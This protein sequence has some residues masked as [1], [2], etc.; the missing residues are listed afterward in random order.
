MSTTITTGEVLLEVQHVSKVY[1]EKKPQRGVR[2]PVVLDD[3]DLQIRAG[4]F[5]A[6]LGPSG[7]GKSTLLRILAGLL[8]PTSGEVLFKG[9][10]QYGPNPH[11][12]I[13]FQSFALFPWFTVLQNVELGLQAQE[14]PRTQRL[15]R[16]LSAID[17]I[18]LDGFEDAYPKE[19]SGGMRQ[20]VGFARALVVEPELLFMDEPFSALD[21]LT[22]ANLRKELM[23]LWQ[24][25]KMPTKAIVMVTHNI[26]DA[27]SMA[28]RILVLGADPGH[29]RAELQGLPIAQRESKEEAY[30]QMVDLIYRI[31]TSPHTSV[32]SLLPPE[33]Q[34]TQTGVLQPPKPPRPYQ[35]LPHV[36]IGDITGLIELVNASGGREDLYQ[37][38][39]DLH[40]E[41]DDL[42]PMVE[43]A[44]LLDLADTREGDLILTSTGQR[45]AEAGVLE[46][47]HIFRE[48]ALARV[49]MLRHIVRDL[50]KDPDHTVSEEVYM[51]QLREHF[52]DDEA[53]SQLETI[54]NWGRYAELFS[55]VEDRG[56]FRLEDPETSENARS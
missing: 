19:L 24:A 22:A 21:V 14:V 15:K 29:I 37:L 26:E 28:D 43:A 32:E 13:V 38:G 50:Q 23:N 46:E 36:D 56:V 27:V 31:M 16:A 42:L 53:W 47:K 39:R 40:L 30:T 9:T 6:L 2:L 25:R 18:G 44:D 45:F 1:E 3:V 55:Y 7:S 8:A 34:K 33:Q 35:T 49:T 51:D 54:I 11:L 17:L 10:P 12:A 41:V 48:Q 4:E 20:R 5:I 52:S